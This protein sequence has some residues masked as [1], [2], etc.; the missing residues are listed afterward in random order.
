M[1][2]SKEVMLSMITEMN[3]FETMQYFVQQHLTLTLVAIFLIPIIINVAIY[4]TKDN[5]WIAFTVSTLVSLLLIGFTYLG[6]IPYFL[7]F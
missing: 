3:S 6:F 4:M 5:Y 1:T 7:T 2:F